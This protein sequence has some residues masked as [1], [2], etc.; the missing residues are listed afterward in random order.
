MSPDQNVFQYTDYR[1]LLADHY[2]E[3][4]ARNRRWNYSVWARQLGL[5]SPSTLVMILKG[6]RHP[7]S[8]LARSIA[9]YLKLDEQRANFFQD[10]VLLQKSESNPRMTVLLLEKLSLKSSGGKFRL[11]SQDQFYAIANWYYYAIRE[12]TK[13]V[14]FHEDAKWISEQL[15]GRVSPALVRVAI[16]K[17]LELGILERGKGGKKL[18]PS[19]GHLDTTTDLAD[20]GL[21]RYH[22]G[23]LEKAKQAV[24]ELAPA[25][26]EISGGCFA[27]KASRIPEAKS[28]IRKFH[29]DLCELLEEEN[30]DVVFQIETSFFPLSKF[31]SENK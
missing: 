22:E 26:R 17:M 4:K 27:I 11:L 12:L 23:V 6:Q 24:R 9:T 3:K 21:K 15:H 29:R 16:D 25:R 18:I 8:D 10:L 2:R 28:L 19:N 20:E 14:G 1:I 5:K 13:V 30:A 31:N 7:S